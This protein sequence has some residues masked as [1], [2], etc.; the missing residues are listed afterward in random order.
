MAI[1]L[2]ILCICLMSAAG[3]A[4]ASEHML[5]EKA[6]GLL[7]LCKDTCSSSDL[8]GGHAPSCDC[9]CHQDPLDSKEVPVVQRAQHTRTNP[10]LILALHSL[11]PDRYAS[12]TSFSKCLSS[13]RVDSSA[14]KLLFL[15]I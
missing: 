5:P 11:L 15:R 3:I 7:I 10:I 14:P 1:R 2:S 6:P 13:S 8:S 4:Q 12:N 9:E